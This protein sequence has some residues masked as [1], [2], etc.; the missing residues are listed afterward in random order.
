MLPTSRTVAF[1]L[2]VVVGAGL[3][4]LLPALLT[5][6][7]LERTNFQGKPIRSGAGLL[8][9][10]CAFP[11]GLMHG[12]ATLLCTVALTGYGVL[13]FIDDR[14][15]T[16][17]FKGL[18]GHFRALRGGRVTTGLVKAVGGVL[19]AGGL[20]LLLPASQSP[21]TAAPLIALCANLLNLLDLRPLR[22]LKGFWF[23]SLGLLPWAPLPLAQVWGLSL[24]YARREAWGELM[25]GDTGSNA[26]GGLLGVCLALQTPSWLQAGLV[27]GLLLFHAWA[28]KHSL[29]RWIEGRAWARAVDRWGRPELTTETRRH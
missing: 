4:R 24:P 3:V 17:E 5:R 22:A 8:F 2:A 25:L 19:L 9:V 16:A 27:A 6:L 10:L 21:V 18:R 7:G 12:R 26:L 14:W 1:L 28:E 15:G 13:G 29:S 23:L 20:A 11:W